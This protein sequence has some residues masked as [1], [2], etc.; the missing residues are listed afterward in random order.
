MSYRDHISPHEFR[1]VHDEDA[2]AHYI[3]AYHPSFGGGQVPVGSMFWAKR[4]HTTPGGI[5]KASPGE[6]YNIEVQ[7]PS[8]HNQVNYRGRGIATEM[9]NRAQSYEPKPLHSSRQTEDGK[10][11]AKRVGGPGV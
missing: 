10:R 5:M 4:E 7:G 8:R 9:Y 3:E 2:D 1:Y 6:I 11:W